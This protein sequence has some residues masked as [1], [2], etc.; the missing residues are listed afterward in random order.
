MHISLRN[1][2]FQVNPGQ[3][4]E[5]W[6]YINTGQWEPQS[7]DIIDF[8][9]K[10]DT[11]FIDIG[12][13]SGVISLYA[14]HIAK[15]VY[16][17]DPDPICFE[18]LEKNISLNPDLSKKI[19]PHQIAIAAVKGSTKLHARKKYG[20]SSSSILS[21]SKD[22]LSTITVKTLSLSDFITK[23]NIHMINFIKMDVEGA[24]FQILPSIYKIL[25]KTQ[26]PTL[27]VSFH[28]NFLLENIYNKYIPFKLFNKIFLKIEKL[29]G[30]C[31]FK[32]EINS[33]IRETLKSIKE[34]KYIYTINGEIISYDFLEKNPIFIKT[35]DL[36]FTNT[37]WK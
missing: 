30:I 27:Y 13:W 21:R 1:H 35:N 29:A 26:Y 36:V 16:S 9:V 18:E 10:K 2:S 22:Q 37:A 4:T 20:M 3:N 23:E 6:N 25:Q 19:K 12:A 31:L 8:F 17:I 15:E 28:Y 33:I 11:T 7:F 34:Y 14:A 24:E 32:R 5:A